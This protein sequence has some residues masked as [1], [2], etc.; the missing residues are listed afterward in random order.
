MQPRSKRLAQPPVLQEVDLGKSALIQRIIYR[1]VR[2]KEQMSFGVFVH[3]RGDASFK[4][5]IADYPS[6][7]ETGLVQPFTL[8]QLPHALIDTRLFNHAKSALKRAGLSSGS[9]D[10][11]RIVLEM[12]LAQTGILTIAVSKKNPS[13]LRLTFRAGAYIGTSD[14]RLKEWLGSVTLS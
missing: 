10:V 3:H 1:G 7:C 2:P 6:S 11:L 9:I 12:L 14:R 4:V 8:E 13:V 5:A